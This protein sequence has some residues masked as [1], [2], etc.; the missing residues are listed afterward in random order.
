M[1]EKQN[2]GKNLFRLFVALALAGFAGVLNY[3]YLNY[4]KYDIYL[5]YNKD[6]AAGELV[7]PDDFS[8]VKIDLAAFNSSNLGATRKAFDETFHKIGPGASRDFLAGKKLSRDVKA[9]TPVIPQ[10]DFTLDA[11][12]APNYTVFGNFLVLKADDSSVTVKP[13]YVQGGKGTTLE[14]SEDTRR[15]IELSTLDAAKDSRRD[16]EDFKIKNIVVRLRSQSES[17]DVGAF[18]A[19]DGI[20]IKLPNGV[21]AEE[22]W[23]NGG[24]RVGFVVETAT[25]TEAEINKM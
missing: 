16:A 9:W 4:A 14:F 13:E 24:A 10:L 19:V 22:E 17:T 11:P 2:G 15:L 3:C 25:L 18:S 21:A 7:R 23:A 20:K 5:C 12:P 6:K 8:A 1:D